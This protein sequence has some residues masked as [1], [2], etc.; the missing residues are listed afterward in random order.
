MK[1][2]RIASLWLD[3][4]SGC[5]MSLLDMDH[6]IIDLAGSIEWVYGPLVDARI[7][8]EAVD[9]TFVEGAVSYDRD[10]RDLLHIRRCTRTLVSFGDCAVTANVPGMRN[11][12]SLP[13]VLHRSYVENSDGDNGLPKG[14]VPGLLARVRPVHEIVMVDI[15]L[16]GCP[17]PTTA[18]AHTLASLLAGT[19]PALETTSRF[20][21]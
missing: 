7:F 17:P 21:A 18:I 20:G 9:I 3:G 15:F 13:D 6:G 5:H 4:C 12:F 14:A 10:I 19:M 8:P 2:C 11:A 16:P 1:K